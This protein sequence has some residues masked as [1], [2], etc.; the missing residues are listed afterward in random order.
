MELDNLSYRAATALVHSYA[1]EDEVAGAHREAMD[2]RD[3]EDFLQ[4]GIDA[5]QWVMRAD[6]VLRRAT[7]E[8]KAAFDPAQAEAGIRALCALW[9]KP[10][11]PANRWIS[12]Q[13]SRGFKVD[14]VE[15]FHECCT[16]MRA[17][18]AAQDATDEDMPEAI[19]RLQDRAIEEHRNGETAEFVWSE[20]LGRSQ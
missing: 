16:E 15:R 12:L 13:E 2:C 9:L 8:G 3:C 7:F 11:E 5:F 20:Q 4:L 18:V 6:Q 1:L 17:I 14:N 10:C 19:A